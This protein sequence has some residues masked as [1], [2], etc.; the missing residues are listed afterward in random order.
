MERFTWGSVRD[1]WKMV[2][3]GA[4]LVFVLGATVALVA[5]CGGGDSGSS[6]S[7]S[8]DSGA[9]TSASSTAAADS[10]TTAADSSTTASADQTPYQVTGSKGDK[11]PLTLLGEVPNRKASKEYNVCYVGNTPINT[12]VQ[13]MEYGAETAAD[14]LGVKLHKEIAN[15]DSA[16]QINQMQALVQ[17]NKCDGMVLFAADPNAEC[18]TVKR[19]A[20]TLPVVVT[21]FP[22]CGDDGYTEGTVSESSSQS[23]PFY[24]QYVDWAFGEL[25]KKGGGKV[26]V[27]S[28]PSTF[29][30]YQQLKRASEEGAKKYPNVKVVQNI[31]A[32]WTIEAGLKQAQTVLQTHPD[33][34]MLLSS[35]DQNTVGAIKALQSAGKKPG[36]IT[37]FDLGGDERT[38]PLLKEGWIQGIQYLQPVEEVGQGLELL[39][40]HLDGQEVPTF[41]NLGA[42]K[43][44]PGNTVQITEANVDQ[45]KPEF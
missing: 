10:S 19:I 31:A 5:G 39:V 36:E 24:K 32:P 2:R 23:Y 20:K 8:G 25:A 22:L 12:Y 28:G 16:E 35:Y 14:A 13:A 43:G 34:D 26:A 27:L 18:N 3:S 41:N 42:G 37:I 30:H 15:W 17:Q 33:V 7:S 9:A 4:A 45:F 1:T 21:N 6:T 40:G 44:L 29:G 11:Q 38:F